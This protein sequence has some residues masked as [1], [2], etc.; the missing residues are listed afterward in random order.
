MTKEKV[1]RTYREFYETYI[2]A[3]HER[4]CDETLHWGPCNMNKLAPE[5]ET[6]W[7][8]WTAKRIYDGQQ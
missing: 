7:K 2:R 4:W 8:L 3:E 1:C 5:S 6:R